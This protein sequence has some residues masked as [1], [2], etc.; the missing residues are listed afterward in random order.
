MLV[1]FELRVSP[2]KRWL[3][4][5]RFTIYHLIL[6]LES[7]STTCWEVISTN[8]ELYENYISFGDLILPFLA[9]HFR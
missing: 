3:C 1:T 4:I 6:S 8:D 7:N 9:M 5:P 2:R